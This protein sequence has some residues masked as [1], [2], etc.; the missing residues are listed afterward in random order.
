[1]K[2]KYVRLPPGRVHGG[3]VGKCESVSAEKASC[4]VKIIG[5]PQDTPAVECSSH[6]VEVG[7]RARCTYSEVNTGTHKEWTVVVLY[8]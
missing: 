2:G 1:M 5:Y 7:R 3:L 8:V 4:F 6:D